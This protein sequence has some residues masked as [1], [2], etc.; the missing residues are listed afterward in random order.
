M[1]NNRILNF[2]ELAL[3]LFSDELNLIGVFVDLLNYLA[4]KRIIYVEELWLSL[5]AADHDALVKTLLAWEDSWLLFLDAFE[6]FHL[7]KDTRE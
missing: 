1:A 6:S 3:G 5:I 7:L 2:G 4:T